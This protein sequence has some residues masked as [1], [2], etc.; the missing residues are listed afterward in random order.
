MWKMAPRLKR[1]AIRQIRLIAAGQGGRLPG[2]LRRMAGR[3]AYLL[4]RGIASDF[5]AD[6]SPVFVV[7]CACVFH[8]EYRGS[9]LNRTL[10]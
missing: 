9:T 4:V 5:S 7:S 10:A 3:I 2:P 1:M 8:N 6:G